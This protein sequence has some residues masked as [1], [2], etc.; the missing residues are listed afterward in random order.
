MI[1]GALALAA[2]PAANAVLAEQPV[3]AS[4]ADEAVPTA[5]WNTTGRVEY[6]EWSRNSAANPSHYDAFLRSIRHNLDG[7]TT[8]LSTVK[9]NTT[10]TGW[11]GGI[12]APIAAYQTVVGGQS[13]VRL[14]NIA[15]GTRSSPPAGVNTPRWEW[16]PTLSGQWL[17][18]GREKL[19]YPH[20]D[21]LVLFNLS[22]HETR[23]LDSATTLG[24]APG[25]VNG[26]YVVWSR[27]VT[28]CNV[29]AYRISTQAKIKLERP[30]PNGDDPEN[31]WAPSVT[32]DGTA[33]IARST[34]G[35]GDGTSI[36]RY[37]A[38]DPPTGTLLVTLPLGIDLSFTFAR[39][40]PG[41]APTTDVFYD[42][43]KCS[44]GSGDVYKIRV[45]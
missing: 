16:Y 43:A 24:L 12:A 39:T 19:T 10:G 35:C 20:A 27:C 8:I 26:D 31:Q 45:G 2:T 40:N 17:L 28:L 34:N 9:L 25:Q 1:L 42:R 44:S 4:L 29:F 21:Q 14:Y 22:S 6:I 18:F 5:G 13:D 33:Y 38:A 37:G 3:I 30:T 15:T 41:A 36:V 32:A 11:P 7:T 23:I